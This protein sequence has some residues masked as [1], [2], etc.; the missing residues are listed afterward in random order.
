M[1][2]GPDH[3]RLLPLSAVLGAAML[4]LADVIGRV[5][6]PPGEVSAG[7]LTALVGVPALIVLLRR[8]VVTL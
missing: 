1:V 2:V 5:I 8:K 3:A 4:T 7:I 6:A